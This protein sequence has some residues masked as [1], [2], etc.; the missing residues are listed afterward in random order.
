MKRLTQLAL[1][2]LTTL[3]SVAQSNF[4]QLYTTNPHPTYQ[5]S[6]DGKTLA[7]TSVSEEPKNRWLSFID[8]ETFTY[9]PL[10]TVS[11][12]YSSIS[13]DF[14]SAFGNEYNKNGYAGNGDWIPYKKYMSWMYPNS[15]E[16][17]KLQWSD[18]HFIL[19][20]RSDGNLLIAG[21]VEHVNKKNTA[22]YV[23]NDLQIMEPQSG[24][25]LSTLRKG[26]FLQV[27]KLWAPEEN[28]VLI[29]NDNLLFWNT[30]SGGSTMKLDGGQRTYLRNSFPVEAISGKWGMGLKTDDKSSSGN[31][32]VKKMIMDLENGNIV[33]E[34][35]IPIKNA[36]GYWCASDNS[37][38]FF[39]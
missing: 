29:N 35:N 8:L 10:G 31:L 6:T 15:T 9:R 34:K 2:L 39:R 23:F 36:N 24:K 11:L 26:E 30:W 33:F 14:K 1:L 5:L 12:N 38:R 4:G 21:N 27:G 18:K 28:P 25:I 20:L 22:Y 37:G 13:S 7:V 19:A 17:K 32:I 16:A 3:N